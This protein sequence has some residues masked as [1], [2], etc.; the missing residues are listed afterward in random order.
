[1]VQAVLG[2]R[3]W[4]EAEF[5]S[6][7]LGDARLT[8]RLVRMAEGIAASPGKSLPEAMPGWAELKAAYRLLDNPKTTRSQVIGPHLERTREGCRGG[9]EWLLVEDTTTLSYGSHRAAKGLGPVNDIPDSRG[10]L[11]HS[12][13]AL[14]VE[15]WEADGEPKV[16][17]A[18]LF[19]QHAWVRPGGKRKKETCARRKN[20]RRE[21]E[22]WAQVFQEA[23]GPPEGSRW[24]LVADRE[25]DVYRALSECMAHRVDFL[26]RAQQPRS[27]LGQDGSAFEAVAAAAPLGRMSLK[28]RSRPGTPARLAVLEL[29]ATKVTLLAPAGQRRWFGPCPVTVVEARE[30]EAPKGVEPVQWVLLTS[31]EASSLAG[32]LRVVRSYAKRWLIEEYHKALK[33]GAGIER[34]QLETRERLEA[35]LGILAVVAVRLLNMKLLCS[36]RPDDQAAAFTLEPGALEV[37][38]A[39]QGTPRGGWTNRNLMVAIAKL[40]GFL[41][42]KGDGNPGWITI[43]RGW[44]SLMLMTRAL[45]L[46]RS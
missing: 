8:D 45:D 42:R 12:T 1:M 32:A 16:T 20:R 4:A 39:K 27:L 23:E 46:F 10:I 28:L 3:A 33:T 31:W 13:L 35:L 37:L 6:A 9:G 26:I 19:G 18:G 25:G 14:A 2:T 21:S 41:G 15:G 34:S 44:N 36:S 22:R 11:L 24:T 5:G 40:G 17:V 29:R 7:Q 38:V 43:W 30:V